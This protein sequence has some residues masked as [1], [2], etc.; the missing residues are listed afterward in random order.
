[1]RDGTTEYIPAE[2]VYVSN[3]PTTDG[4]ADVPFSRT[5][6]PNGNKSHD[7]CIE[8]Q[9]QLIFPCEKSTSLLGGMVRREVCSHNADALI[10]G[11]TDAST[12]EFPHMVLL[13]YGQSQGSAVWQCGGTLISDRFILTAAH[14][15]R[16]KGLGYV[17]YAIVGSLKRTDDVEPW[18]VRRIRRII[19]HPHFNPY[20]KHND[21]ALLE[22]DPI[23]LGPSTVPACLDV[24]GGAHDRSVAT[25]WG[26][27][28]YL[29]RVSD[30][31]QKVTLT[32]F[33]DRKCSE[34][35][36]V[37]R[38]GAVFNSTIQVC[39]GD[40]QNR[41]D[42]CQGDSG[43]PLTILNHGIHCMYTVVGITSFGMNCGSVGVPGWY[44]KVSHY[45]PWIESIVWP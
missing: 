21:I 6:R 38:F 2:E 28:D 19:K 29:G 30:T 35:Y 26:V 22:T 31:L 10:V 14:C 15:T 23:S 5:A 17:N 4:C 18:Q 7:K 33:T 1:M 25:G 42:T 41:A 37:N 39:Y 20:T 36:P 12:N 13:G 3:T 32:K 9:K 34:N 27:T 40:Y 24:F 16:T 44:T 43:G 8:Y 11:G 45:V